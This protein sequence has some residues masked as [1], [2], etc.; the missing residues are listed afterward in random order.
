MKLVLPCLRAVPTAIIL[1]K[2]AK[3]LRHHM[4]D[5]KILADGI[6]NMDSYNFSRHGGQKHSILN[7]GPYLLLDKGVMK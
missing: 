2:D 7:G 4:L 6:Y 5:H 3:I 1:S